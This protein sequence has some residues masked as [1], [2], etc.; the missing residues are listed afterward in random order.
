[1]KTTFAYSFPDRDQEDAWELIEDQVDLSKET[2]LEQKADRIAI[3]IHPVYYEDTT[4]YASISVD[5]DHGFEE[6]RKCF[7][8]GHDED[9]STPCKGCGLSLC[10]QC[11][12]DAGCTCMFD[13]SRYVVIDGSVPKPGQCK[14]TTLSRAQRKKVIRGSNTVKKQDEAMWAMLTGNIGSVAKKCLL[15]VTMFSNVFTQGIGQ[16]TTFVDPGPYG[17]RCDASMIT[18]LN[19]TF[20]EEQ[21]PSL[22]YIHVPFVSDYETTSGY[23]HLQ[24]F[25]KEQMSNGRTCIIADTRFTDRWSDLDPTPCKGALAF[26][27]NDVEVRNELVEWARQLENGNPR[28]TDDLEKV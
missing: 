1:M 15:A 22:L 24:E 20:V 19:K 25:A 6:D 23:F 16:T 7:Y 10:N 17:N 21:D 13:E 3:I 8:C 26:H 14:V 12:T 4:K 18:E 9:I 11:V 2:I 5:T 28:C 27:C